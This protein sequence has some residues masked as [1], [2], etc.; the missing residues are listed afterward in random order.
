M[1]AKHIAVVPSMVYH[2]NTVIYLRL[3]RR[4]SDG[5]W[6]LYH[7]YYCLNDPPHSIDKFEQVKTVKAS[8][9]I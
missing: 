8:E 2:I 1:I 9:T 3:L 7:R 5:F 6:E 4:K